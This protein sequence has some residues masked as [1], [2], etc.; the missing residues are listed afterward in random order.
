MLTM[1]YQGRF[2]LLVF[3]VFFL[4]VLVKASAGYKFGHRRRSIQE[5]VNIN[6]HAD[7]CADIIGPNWNITKEGKSPCKTLVVWVPKKPGFTE[8]VKVN[9][10][11][12]VEGGFSIAIFCYALQK[13]P[14]NI[15]PIFKPFINDTGQMNGTYDELLK[16]IKGQ[17]CEAVAGDVT[18]R[19]QRTQYVSFTAPYLSSELYMLVDATHEWNQTLGT[20]LRP[21]TNRLW[22]TLVCACVL[23]GITLA[24]LEYRAGNPKFARPFYKQLIMV[25]W[26]PISS[27]FFHEGKI[28][29][30]CSK[31]V[32]VTWL[33]MIFIVV[34]IFTATLS[35]W[36]TLDQLRPKLPSSFQ[37]VGYQGGSFIKQHIIEQYQC[38]V[39]SLSGYEDYK[40]ALSDGSVNAVFDELPYIDLFLS[41]YGSDDYMKHG[42]IILESGIAFAFAHRSPLLQIFSEAV[43]NVTES[44]TMMEM[45]RRYLGISALDKSQPNRALPQSLDVQSFIGL[46]IFMGIVMIGSIIASEISLFERNNKVQDQDEEEEEPKELALIYV[47]K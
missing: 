3:F 9:E 24:I 43:I 10:Q 25:M 12:E 39:Q 19:G 1:K 40:N 29:N 4:G 21:F 36:L 28:L 44:E 46:F 11:N 8:F 20:F 30:K 41:K 27:F 33:C 5:R 7:V 34:Q 17:T 26:F 32:L 22:I 16:H 38:K 37:N 47:N 13:L 31:V 23:I 18:I 15:Q 42:P 45:K 2:Y 6:G 14:F 35:S